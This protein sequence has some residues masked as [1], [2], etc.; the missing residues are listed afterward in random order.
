V[1]PTLLYTAASI[2]TL[3]VKGENY[4]VTHRYREAIGRRVVRFDPFCAEGS[5]GDTYNP[6]DWL[7]EFSDDAVSDSMMIAEA[8]V[9]ESGD[10]S[11]FGNERHW[12]ETAKDFLRGLIL[13]VS[14]L[15]AQRRNLGELRRILTLPPDELRK[16]VSL[17]QAS[18]NP[19]V[20]RLANGFLSLEERERSSLLS[21]A[22]RHTAFLD[23]DRVA[24]SLASSSFNI[25]DLK[26]SSVD[27]YLLIPPE[28]MAAYSRLLRLLVSLTITAVTRVRGDRKVLWLLDEFAQLGRMNIIE[29]SVSLLRGFGGAFWIFVQDL[30]QLKAV[31]PK[32]QTFVANMSKQFFAV[33]DYD[34]AKYLSDTIGEMTVQFWTTGENSHGGV[35]S[36]MTS[37][38]RQYGDGQAVTEHLQARKLI[39]PD[40]IMSMSQDHTIVIVSG[41]RPYVI[42]KLNY[43]RDR[44]YQGLYDPNPLHS[45]YSLLQEQAANKGIAGDEKEQFLPRLR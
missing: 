41:E 27:I 19:I 24:L 42:W 11:G 32:W 39:A 18:F 17:M 21:T 35:S 34:S 45:S 15:D 29:N 16:V 14:G 13:Y 25:A 12:D 2:V 36:G 22:R 1:I 40:E 7:N 5:A 10:D 28:K 31:Y 23:D 37:S 20:Q 6:I 43:L 33:A 9:I 44:E 38:S 8:L 30:A 4:A 26:R 3:D